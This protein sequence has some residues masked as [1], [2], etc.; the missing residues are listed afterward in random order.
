M[1]PVKALRISNSASSQSDDRGEKWL[2]AHLHF[3]GNPNP[4]LYQFVGPF[5]NQL[6][7]DRQIDRYFFMRYWTEGQHIRVRMLPSAN[8]DPASVTVAFE[9]AAAAFFE[10]RPSLLPAMQLDEPDRVKATFLAEYPESA[11]DAAYG[12]D[13]EMPVRA[14]N[15]LRWVSYKPEF[16]RYGGTRGM[17]LSETHF[18]SSSDLVLNLLETSNLH[19]RSIVLG[20]AAQI[21]AVMTVAMLDGPQDALRFLGNYEKR[22]RTGWGGIYSP[23]NEQFERAYQAQAGV[24]VPRVGSVIAVTRAVLA[25]ESR[26]ARSYL[27]SWARQCRNTRLEINELTGANGLLF[28]RS[29]DSGTWDS[30]GDADFAAHGL[31]FSYVHMLNN[32]LGVPIVDEIYLAYLLRRTL[33]DLGYRPSEKVPTWQ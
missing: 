9:A 8:V 24:L 6:R 2:S 19:I 32:R 12:P 18:E 15:Q 29:R 4:M 11:W 27:E 1:S 5:L 13:G 22:W 33:E 20:A 3:S 30:Q 31:A 21:M 23:Q 28:P 14:P 26:P 7:D 25:D 16:A 10:R 17:T